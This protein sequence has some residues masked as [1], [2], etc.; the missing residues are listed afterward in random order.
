MVEVESLST[1]FGH[2]GLAARLGAAGVGQVQ[3]RPP[4]G[5]GRRRRHAQGRAG[6]RHTRCIPPS[7]GVT[8]PNPNIDF[9][10]SPLYINTELTDWDAPAGTVRSAG[11]SAF[12]FGGT[13]FHVVMEEYVPGPDGCPALANRARVGRAGPS[14]AP[15]V[16]EGTPPRGAGRRWRHRRRRAGPARDRARGRGRRRRAPTPAPPAE[17]DLRAAVRVAIDYADAAELAAK[18]AKAT[19]GARERQRR[20]VEDAAATRA[21]SWAGATPHQVAFLYTGQGSQYVNMLAGLRQTEPLVAE[22]FDEADRVMEPI[23][24]R[25]LSDY[26]FA[27]PDDEQ[28]MSQA[29]EELRQ[30]EITQPAV[31]ATDLALTRLLAAY[32][33]QPD[34]V[35]GH[36]LGEYAALGAAGA[37]PFADALEAV[38]AR[39]REMTAVSVDD[40]GLMAAVFAPLEEIQAD[41]RRSRRLRGHRQ[42]QQRRPRPSSAAPRRR[43]RRRWND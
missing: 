4:Q 42:P 36:S 5:G 32:G 15:R 19:P 24:G 6:A 29:E 20:R 25:P 16:A 23:L 28:A 14:Q 26:I 27:D 35:M 21:S 41:P 34:M 31:L 11:V 1:V 10:D 22:V 40:N 39:G 30:T 7:I 12:G 43:C 9:A 37:L 2:L 17:A 3:H 8:A 13:N 38:A 18:T 33:I